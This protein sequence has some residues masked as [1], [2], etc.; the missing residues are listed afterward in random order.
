MLAFLYLALS[1]LTGHAVLKNTLPQLFD[2]GREKSFFGKPV[3][4]GGWMVVFPAYFLV[5]TLVMTWT[6]YLAAYAFR[7]TSMPMFYGNLIAFSVFITLAAY[8]LLSKRKECGRL[9]ACV[10]KVTFG[11]CMTFLRER[12][13]ELA[14]LLVLLAISGFL[15]FYTFNV[16]D[17]I[18][19]I[20]LSVF[21]DFGPHLSIIRSFSRGHNF[22]TQYPLFPDGT[23]RYHFMFQFLAGNLEFL[24]LPLDWAFNLPSILSFTAFLMLLYSL[25]VILMGEPAV[26][27]MTVIL[28]LFRSS[29]AFFSYLETLGHVSAATL[30]QKLLTNFEFIGK[31]ASEDWGLWNM[32]VYANQRHLAFSL[33]LLML[34]LIIAVPSFKNM[35]NSLKQANSHRRRLYELL[36]KRDAWQPESVLH[37]VAVGVLLGLASFW[38]GA[39]VIATWLFLLFLAFFSKRRLNFLIILAISA[40]LVYAETAFFMGLGNSPVHPQLNVGFL[41]AQ[42]DIFGISAYYLELLGIL[43]FVLIAALIWSAPNGAWLLAAAFSIPLLFATL[44]QLTPDVAVGHKY[45]IISVMLLNIL[46]AN[47]LHHLISSGKMLKIAIAGFLVVL[48]TVTGIVDV[49]TIYNRDRAEKAM[50]FDMNDPLLLWVGKNTHPNDVFLTDVYWLHPVL[51]A[52]RRIFYG[53]PYYAWS[54]GYDTPGRESLVNEIYGSN[55]TD[56]VKLL[57]REQGIDYI[58]IDDENRNSKSYTLNENVIKKSFRL[59]YSNARTEVYATADMPKQVTVTK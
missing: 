47:F 12:R 29:F 41:A 3:K 11:Q 49:V 10:K 17:G 50:T 16:R 59:V 15:M 43:P 44:V 8:S 35:I 48:L 52:G 14:F 30:V 31:T 40:I 54:A 2:I 23:M 24:G 5:G 1:F 4:L 28:F 25:A 7:G 34:V 36:L 38:N 56:R 27:I 6:T 39:V 51:L 22:P 19:R 58:V 42:H 9:L 46:I 20:G 37:P 26:G 32:N 13:R 45:V 57:V 18:A 33:G 53:W 55:D 21:G